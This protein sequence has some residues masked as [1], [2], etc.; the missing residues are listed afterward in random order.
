MENVDTLAVSK[1]IRDLSKNTE[2][3]KTE[4][5]RVELVNQKVQKY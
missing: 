3:Y 2:F 4:L 1:V 5:K